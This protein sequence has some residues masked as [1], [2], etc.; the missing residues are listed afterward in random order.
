[1]NKAE[2]D[3][4]QPENQPNPPIS[5]ADG[6]TGDKDHEA[7]QWA[8]ARSEARSRRFLG[9]AVL[10]SIFFVIAAI[11]VILAA[12]GQMKRFI[13]RPLP[14]EWVTVPSGEFLMGAADGDVN[15]NSDEKPQH[16]VYLDAFEIMAYEVT[17]AQYAQCVRA[18]ICLGSESLMAVGDERK[19]HPVTLVN[20]FDAQTFC[21]LVGGRLPT[22]AEWEKAAHGGLDGA[23]YPWGDAPPDCSRV[24]FKSVDSG[25]CVGEASPVGSYAPNGYGL[26]DMAGNVWEWVA[27]WYAEDYYAN[28]PVENP[29][30]P[31]DGMYCVMRGGSWYFDEMSL[32]LAVRSWGNPKARN[33]IIGF[34]CARLP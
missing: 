16:A 9:V 18:G 6:G 22:E 2:N 7:P 33:E 11:A 4:T 20:W 31:E 34:R 30:G 25:Y 29:Q 8:Q 3:K 24:N 1:M 19:N 14:V 21:A 10:V 17:N 32:R 15:A 12:S 26:Y 13:Y 28:S 23:L 27:D 5:R